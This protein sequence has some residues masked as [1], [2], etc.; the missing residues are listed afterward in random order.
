MKARFN[1]LTILSEDNYALGRFYEGFFHMRPSGNRGPTDPVSLGDG[2]IGINIHPRLPGTKAQLNHFGIE[3]DDVDQALARIREHFPA[4]EWREGPDGVISTHDPAGNFFGLYQTGRDTGA[5]FYT[6]EGGT[7]DRA[8]DHIGLRVINFEEVAD[9]YV[10][11][12]GFTP[13]DGPAGHDNIYL[14]DGHIRLVI[15][16]WRIN[17]FLG[18][19]ITARGMDHIG[20]RVESLDALKADVARMAERNYRFQPR[21]SMVGRGKEGGQRLVMF[22]TTCPLGHHHMAD[23]DGLW[24]DVIE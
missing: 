4:V 5:D 23:S 1:H 7:H 11:V 22:Q 3:V 2:N 9:F 10:K 17:D 24:L 8:V 21:T 18:T 15:V 14:S 19:G 20:F 12:F 6:A 13:C 16:P